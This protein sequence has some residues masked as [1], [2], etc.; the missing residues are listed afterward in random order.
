MLG[1]GLPFQEK[2]IIFLCKGKIVKLS[3]V[4]GFQH[5]VAPVT[6]QVQ[7]CRNIVGPTLGISIMQQTQ[8]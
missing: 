5:L 4:G 7:G 2:N 3:S 6:P 8:W 1:M